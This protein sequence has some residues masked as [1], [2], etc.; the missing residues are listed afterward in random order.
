MHDFSEDDP[1]AACCPFVHQSTDFFWMLFLTVADCFSD[2]LWRLGLIFVLA[3]V[4]SF[5]S[6]AVGLII[7]QQNLE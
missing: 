7:I 2:L 6:T 5:G 4:P 1:T 3:C